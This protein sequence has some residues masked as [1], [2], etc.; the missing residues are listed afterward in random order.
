MNKNITNIFVLLL[1]TAFVS[2]NAQESKKV[3]CPEIG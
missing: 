3:S 2:C 1:L